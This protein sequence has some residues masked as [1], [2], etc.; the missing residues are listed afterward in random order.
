MCGGYMRYCNTI[1]RRPQVIE[2]MNPI[3]F[4]Y[5]TEK[6][7]EFMA[8]YRKMARQKWFQEKRWTGFIG[9]WTKGIYMQVYKTH[10]FNYELN[11]IH[12]ETALTPEM[13]KAKVANLQLH[14]THQNLLPSRDD[15]NDYTIP[16]FQKIIDVLGE[17]YELWE[18][19]A[20]ERM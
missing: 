15:F 19:R 16:R 4:R 12:F 1:N 20:S 2:Q 8:A 7:P 18:H 6:Q 9:P 3:G 5:F 11:G 14:I 13:E 17:P 10:W